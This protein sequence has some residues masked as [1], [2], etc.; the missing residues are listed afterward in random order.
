M[1]SAA[2]YPGL[3]CEIGELVIP[4]SRSGEERLEGEGEGRAGRG[5]GVLSCEI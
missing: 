4:M 5:G 1:S 3:G 2:V